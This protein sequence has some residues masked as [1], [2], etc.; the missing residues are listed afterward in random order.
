MASN[1]E[2]MMAVYRN[3][4][5][6]GIPLA[7]YNFM[8]ANGKNERMAREHGLGIIDHFSGV[9]MISPPYFARY[10][11]MSEVKNSDFSISFYWEDDELVE[12]HKF[13]TP[14]G[15]VTQHVAKEPGYGSYYRKKHYIT[16]NEDY[17]IIQYIVENTIFRQ[18]NEALSKRKRELGED[19]VV[20]SRLDRSPH[21]KMLIELTR[22]EKFLVDLYQEPTLVEELMETIGY[23]L[24][25]QFKMAL[26]SEAEIIWAPDNITSD[27]T[28]PYSFEKYVA[29]IYNKFGKQCEEAD[30]VFAVHMDGK[31]NALKEHISKTHI[32]VIES[33]SFPEVGG[34][35]SIAEVKEAF[36]DKVVC[37]NFPSPLSRKSKD[38]IKD[39]LRNIFLE[40]GENKPFMIEISEDIPSEYYGHVLSTLSEFVQE[41]ESF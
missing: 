39:Y 23:R 13:E 20:F 19:G 26:E 5:P 10:E 7:C 4:H 31:L 27:M 24:E 21:Q 2:K 32:N 22:P 17:K 25:E 40:F 3:K 28:P 1:R 16:D 30:K 6:Q 35:L 34:D 36:P 11:S 18:R 14:V 15:E 9:S 8:L 37:P 33:F 41:Q 38:E 12:V 29:P